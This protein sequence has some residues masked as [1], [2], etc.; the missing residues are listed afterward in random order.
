[1]RG[2]RDY[3][4]VFDPLQRLRADRVPQNYQQG[5]PCYVSLQARA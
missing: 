5:V 3:S 1:M 2:E 4:P